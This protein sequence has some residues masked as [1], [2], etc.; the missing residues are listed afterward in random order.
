MNV[1]LLAPVVVGLDLSLRGTG[2]AHADGSTETYISV[3]KEA[4]DHGV[5]R[6]VEIR[7]HVMAAVPH[8]VELVMME[9]LAFDSHDTHRW[10]A[11]LAGVVRVGL[12][13]SDAAFMLVAPGTLKK[14]ATGN[15]HASKYE[16]IQAAERRLHYEGASDDEA[17]ALWLRAIGWALLE[18]PIVELPQLNRDALKV[19]RQQRPARRP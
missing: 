14:Y 10:N 2:I 12:Y 17:D 6:I 1:D 3:A 5:A 7:D 15:G 4:A 11:Q 9:G 13:D 16:V 19:L 8:D 18:Q